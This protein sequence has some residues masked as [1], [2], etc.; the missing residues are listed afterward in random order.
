VLRADVAAAPRHRVLDTGGESRGHGRPPA[1]GSQKYS[2]SPPF[3]GN[4][5]RCR[6]RPRIAGL[7]MRPLQSRRNREACAMKK[8]EISAYGAPE[9]VARCVDAPELGSP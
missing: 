3:T 5:R 2:T 8:V 9:E 6:L 7:T 4:R 1:T